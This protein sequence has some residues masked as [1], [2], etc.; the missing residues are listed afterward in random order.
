[1]SFLI[2]SIF[3][4]PSGETIAYKPWRYNKIIEEQYVIAK[5]LNTSLTDIDKMPPA[6]RLSILNLLKAEADRVKEKVTKMN[7]K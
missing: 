4:S 6:E 3:N 7:K 1:M 2:H 5:E